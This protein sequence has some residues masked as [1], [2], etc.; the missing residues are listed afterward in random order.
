QDELS[1]ATEPPMPKPVTP[2]PIVLL[3]PQLLEP[4]NMLGAMYTLGVV[5][6]LW[7]LRCDEPSK[8]MLPMPI[9]ADTPTWAVPDCEL[10]LALLEAL[11]PALAPVL[12][13]WPHA[14]NV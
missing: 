10:E 11:E 8:V 2:T 1:E 13:V 4:P 9:C 7:C 12:M 14:L 3:W 5:D 6:M